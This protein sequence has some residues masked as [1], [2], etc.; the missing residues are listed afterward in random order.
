ML[1]ELYSTS[2]GLRYVELK[3]KMGVADATLT[4]RLEKLVKQGYVELKAT[5]VPRGRNVMQYTLTPRGRK[6]VDHHHILDLFKK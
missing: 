3:D 4:T 6:Y 1:A 5:Y 2:Q